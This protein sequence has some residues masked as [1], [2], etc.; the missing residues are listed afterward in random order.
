MTIRLPTGRLLMD[1]P[2]DVF[3]S[4]SVK[5]GVPSLSRPVGVGT[6]I[7]SEVHS[8]PILFFDIASTVFDTAD[9]PTGMQ[10]KIKV[11]IYCTPLSLL[12]RLNLSLCIVLL[13]LK[14]SS[15]LALAR[16]ARQECDQKATEK[17]T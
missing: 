14:R 1:L 10:Q 15:L 16:L 4:A 6:F 13:G 9:G 12:L 7:G 8:R 3:T 5:Y 2:F 17:A 11:D